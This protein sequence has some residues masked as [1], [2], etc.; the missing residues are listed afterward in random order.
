MEVDLSGLV[1]A[2]ANGV[3]ATY[4]GVDISYRGLRA[5]ID[6]A[7][8]VVAAGTGAVDL[9]VGK[10]PEAIALVAACW[11]E[12]RPFLLPPSDLGAEARSALRAQAG[13]RQVV[14]AD[15]TIKDIQT[16]KD[17]PP[18]KD[19]QDAV[20]TPE[21]DGVGPM[22]TTSGSTGLPKVVPLPRAAVDRFTEWAAAAFG[23]GAGSVVFNHAPLNFDL[24]LLD[25]WTTL[26]AGGHVV[27][28]E[29]DRAL[30]GRALAR[31]FTSADVEVV[32]AVPLF[33][34]Q[35]LDATD[36]VFPAVRELVHTGDAMPPGLLARLPERFPHARIRNIYGC[37]E[38]NDSFV[39]DTDPTAGT[40]VPIGRPIDGVHARLDGA[41][42]LVSTPFQA[43]R[44]LDAARADRWVE[45]DGRVWFRTGDLVRQTPDGVFH[46]DGRADFQVKVR[47]VR[48]NV[49]QVEEA[50]L[51]HP[52][53]TEAIV[54]ALPDD[55]AGYR[56]HA[57]V[58]P[59]GEARPNSLTLRSHCARL[60]PRTA[61]PSAVELIGA[62]FPR[63]S[64]GKVDRKKLLAERV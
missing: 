16:G 63:T 18:V 3:A 57:L 12:G 9:V 56:L 42:L 27:L 51:N 47:G 48:T 23:I 5:L 25:V 45:Q 4:K 54:L 15:L 1:H 21:L 52:D 55:E 38:T 20:G 64:T 46:L 14:H 29:P 32:Q 50:L 26:R 40:P 24:C 8:R 49:R 19:V 7:R 37:T 39:H 13:C 43:E 17:I 6:Q 22:L 59:V 61:V 34:R 58:R 33:F 36:A 53:V 11:V 28:A 30:D 41:E 10:S 35:L 2:R 60:L 62:E 31:A 44:Y